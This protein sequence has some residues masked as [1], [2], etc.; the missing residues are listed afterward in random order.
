MCIQ[1]ESRGNIQSNS[2][3]G[4]TEY[5]EKLWT[6]GIVGLQLVRGCSTETVNL[7]DSLID[8]VESILHGTLS[9]P[10]CPVQR[11]INVITHI[12]LQFL[13]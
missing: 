3:N 9:A 4:K 10:H 5:K 8:N 11:C 12:S 1:T 6:L 2:L 13:N 7:Y